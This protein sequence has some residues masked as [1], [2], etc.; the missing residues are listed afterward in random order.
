MATIGHFND[1]T[2]IRLPKG[3]AGVRFSAL[4]ESSRS[5][6]LANVARKGE[7]AYIRPGASK[8]KPNTFPRQV[9]DTRRD[10]RPEL[11]P[12]EGQ[13]DFVLGPERERRQASITEIN[14][15][16]LTFSADVHPAIEAGTELK[17]VTV[18]IGGSFILGDLT[19]LNVHAS[20][21]SGVQAG[22]LFYPR[23]GADEGTWLSALTSLIRQGSA[24]EDSETGVPLLAIRCGSCHATIC[25]SESPSVVFVVVCE[26]CSQEHTLPDPSLVALMGTPEGA[27]ELARENGIDLPGAYSVLLGILT[28]EQVRDMYGT[29][30][31]APAAPAATEV[32]SA[33]YDSGFQKA[34]EA[35]SL[36][37][38]EAIQRGDRT[39]FASRMAKR[40]GL[41]MALAL[42]V[43]DNR[44]SLLNAVR[45]QGPRKRIRV[46]PQRVP[47]SGMPWAPAFVA[48]LLILI[49][50]IG[51]HKGGQAVN[52]LE[53]DERTAA[54]DQR[55]RMIQG[56]RV[57]KDELGRVIEVSG[58]NPESVLTAYCRPG[59]HGE[60]EIALPVPPR[61]GVRW[62]I[63]TDH[64]ASG[65]RF[66]IL[67]Q[68]RS[69]AREWVAGDGSNPIAVT[70]APGL[71]AGT[72]RYPI[73]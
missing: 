15:A 45:Q 46:G 24:G 23:V 54:V 3:L 7:G 38:A 17:D 68:R 25:L 14:L 43:A 41:P 26:S 60:L 13:V 56:T 21:G 42:E 39:A 12:G 57:A 18:R 44:L 32:M 70:E 34:V 53:Q 49:V 6:G 10:P 67:I 22:C 20:S 66:A 40:H 4:S 61:A 55:Q 30:Q 31:P 11:P 71:P 63:F 50:S 48:V 33:E 8:V 47:T 9:S 69:G 29:R 62:G 37:V 73:R 27:R 65:S 64:D 58:P 35:G 16:G 36:T 72:P 52:R 1:A 19:L 2:V 28:L 51:A 5:D 59:Q